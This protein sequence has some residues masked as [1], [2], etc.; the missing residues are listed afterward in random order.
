MTEEIKIFEIDKKKKLKNFITFLR[1]SQNSF[2][3]VTIH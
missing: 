1:Q 3:F 2:F